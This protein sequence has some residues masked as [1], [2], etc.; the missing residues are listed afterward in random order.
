MKTDE[1]K[2]F[3]ATTD[4]G[5]S[6]KLYEKIPCTI[7]YVYL[8]L[9]VDGTI[10]PCCISRVSTGNLNESSVEEI[11]HGGRQNAFR[12]KLMR[13]NEDHFFKKDPEWAFC[14][15]CSHKKANMDNFKLMSEIDDS[16]RK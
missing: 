16:P 14:Q 4:G 2:I 11:W 8:R 13:I 7:G 10:R 5:Y 9:E 6:E 15:Q 1:D 12:D 3:V